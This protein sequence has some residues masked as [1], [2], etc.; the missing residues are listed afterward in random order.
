MRKSI[1]GPKEVR[2]IWKNKKNSS[3]IIK[4]A[5]AISMRPMECLRTGRLIKRTGKIVQ[6]C[7][8]VV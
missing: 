1:S 4:L 3:N 7:W 6:M 8:Y 5:S 2:I